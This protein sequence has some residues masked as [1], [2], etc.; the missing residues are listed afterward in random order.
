MLGEDL[1]RLLCSQFAAVTNLVDPNTRRGR[2]GSHQAGICT[3][4]VCK[5]ALVVFVLWF[6][7]AVAHKIES[8]HGLLTVDVHLLRLPSA[9]HQGKGSAG[10]LPTGTS[11]IGRHLVLQI[12][13]HVSFTRD[14]LITDRLFEIALLLATSPFNEPDTHLT[15]RL[16][17]GFASV[18]LRRTAEPRKRETAMKSLVFAAFG[19][20]WLACEVA[21]ADSY[22]IV[23]SS[24]TN[25]DAEW[26]KVVTSL[27]NKH[28]GAEVITW[29]DRVDEA[30]P[31]LRRNHP[32]YT[33]FVATPCKPVASLFAESVP[34][35]VIRCQGPNA[36]AY[37]LRDGRLRQTT[38]SCFVKCH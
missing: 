34:C 31:A 2:P 19:I 35:E 38:A 20:V 10:R 11:K 1:S 12:V 9:R 33:C 14:T 29:S 17:R 26:N 7:L 28:K 13:W 15:I 30:L 8:A 21:W 16:R 25:A 6:R 18:C 22:S 27:T 3:P 36:V 24:A 23:V 32:R 4:H 5:S 37:S